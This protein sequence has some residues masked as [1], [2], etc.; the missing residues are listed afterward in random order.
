M[1]NRVQY[2]QN[3]KNEIEN[4][5][6]EVQKFIDFK[7]STN[8]D[9]HFISELFIE[10][11]LNE[12]FRDK[13]YHFT[14]LNYD[15][16]NSPAID[17]A[18][19]ENG[20]SYQVT[21]T[22][23]P[24]NIKSK[25]IKT[26][27]SFYKRNLHKKYK[28]LYIVIASGISNKK[29]LPNINHLKSEK[30]PIRIDPNLFKSEHI[31]DLKSFLTEITKLNSERYEQILNVIYKIPNR[32]K[33]EKFK[34]NL[35]HQYLYR[36][37]SNNGIHYELDQLIEAQ[38]RIL[39]VGIGGL[40]KTTETN[41][42]QSEWS[43]KYNWFCFRLNFSDYLNDLE[44][45]LSKSKF[46]KNWQNTPQNQK[47]LIIF[48]GLDEINKE[49]LHKV[50]IEIKQF[51]DDYPQFNIILTCR[52]N[53]I[54]FLNPFIEKKQYLKLEINELTETQ[55]YLYI[56]N[57]CVNSTAILKHIDEYNLCDILK[58]PFYL[59]NGVE[60]FASE[61]R[62]KTKIDFL[63][64]LVES[65]IK[66][67]KEK[68]GNIPFLLDEFEFQIDSKTNYL[69]LVMLYAGVYQ[70]SNSDF[71]EVIKD[72][73]AR[74]GSQRL[75]LFR[76]SSD[77]W[78]FEHKIFQDYFASNYFKRKGIEFAKKFLLNNRRIGTNSSEFIDFIAN[79][80]NI[81][82][83]ECEKIIS[84]GIKKIMVRIKYLP[85]ELNLSQRTNHFKKIFL[86]HKV[87][88]T[89]IWKTN[90]D[91]QDLAQYVNLNK[92]PVLIKFLLNE[93][94]PKDKMI[95]SV[96]N[97]VHLLEQLD[98]PG[99]FRDELK[100][101]YL[102]LLT[103]K[104]NHKFGISY[105][106]LNSFIKWQLFEIELKNKLTQ[107]ETLFA[108][109]SPVISF[110]Q[111]LSKGGFDDIDAD[112]VYKIIQSMEMNRVIG[113]AYS[114]F[115]VIKLLSLHDLTHLIQKLTPN[116]FHGRPLSWNKDL[117]K[118]INTQAINLYNEL[119]EIE[120][121]VTDYIYSSVVYHDESYAKEFKSFYENTNIVFKTFTNCFLNDIRNGKAKRREYFAVPALIADK[122]C[123]DWAIDYYLKNQFS[124][125]MMWN[126]LIALTH[127]GNHEGHS[128]VLGKIKEPTQGRFEPQP[129]R[130]EL[131]NKKKEE[132]FLKVILDNKST[133][134]YIEL[135][136]NI[137]K[138]D[139]IT[140]SEV[141]EKL[142]NKE[143]RFKNIDQ[144][145]G[146]ELIR[147]HFEESI[148]KQ[149]FLNFY[150]IEKN[151]ED[152]VIDEYNNRITYQNIPVENLN[153]LRNW[154]YKVLPSIVFKDSLTEK[155]YLIST[156]NFINYA[157]FLDLQME[158]K[159]FLEMTT[160]LGFIELNS[161]FHNNTDENIFYEYLKKHIPSEILKKQLLINLKEGKL[162]DVVLG[163]HIWIIEK[164][165]IIEAVELLPNYINN[166]EKPKYIR[167]KTL[168]F[169]DKNNGDLK[170]II[171]ILN[172]LSL[173]GNEDYFDWNVID[174]F[175]KNERPEV[176]QFLI[177]SIDKETIDQLKIGIYLL[178]AGNKIAFDVIPVK[179]RLMTN[180]S[181]N[182]TLTL[183]ISQ[184]SVNKFD[185]TELMNFLLN[186]LQIYTKKNF[187]SFGFNNI[188]PALFNK[189]FELITKTNL[190]E[191]IILNVSIR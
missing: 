178:K 118:Q 150:S 61:N 4:G 90:Y 108:Q 126:F 68:E 77:K 44:T 11:L 190:D 142:F 127:I 189:L 156:Y 144:C 179:L 151:W 5:L 172:T 170:S 125:E 175:I 110:C 111:Y 13:G 21:V 161:N 37:F 24:D 82:K 152:L 6:F 149:D 148:N 43:S 95:Q 140:R 47:A 67:E 71:Q 91:S 174:Y 139:I 27:E 46:C 183:T 72:V 50:L 102:E 122:Q 18:D 60:L 154:C 42:I 3:L 20:I 55:I 97:A 100:S 22:N 87:E 1:M 114:L 93:L 131:F 182:E 31:I 141:S 109:D 113:S 38:K 25:V 40:G 69:A 75:F 28:K 123:L 19:Q 176:I 16:F 191:N 92:N 9:I 81:E 74:H 153:W 48:D 133:L 80:M 56:K 145:V 41:R 54:T 143:E 173:S 51:S 32:P 8:K 155:T 83:S 171:P 168:E 181:E 45:S 112:L 36:T 184:I 53:E 157:I 62:P 138:N 165:N 166:P 147:R 119:S 128:Y 124:D 146:L 107:I 130:Y 26:L 180:H 12:I 129:N 7:K 33:K 135:G 65:R 115:E 89:I 137:F 34:L 63:N 49:E 57:K 134:K 117:F 59:V 52:T 185:Q 23:D 39:I 35:E 162:V 186:M 169:Y 30:E 164:E 84:E 163:K 86:K 14:N 132:L 101:K 66:K 188:L 17:I 158:E 98:D 120:K 29:R 159:Y 76:K 10:E 136:L 177:N 15:D 187:G 85:E 105:S 88:E 96:S 79:V 116:D 64:A 99:N 73:N 58:N 103:D 94:V 2:D 167:S 121:V 106:I 70:I 160:W 78:Y 104:E